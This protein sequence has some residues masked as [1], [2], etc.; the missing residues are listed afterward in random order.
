LRG[1]D[2]VERR[3]V[4]SEPR[5]PRGIEVLAEEDGWAVEDGY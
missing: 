5:T 1:A 2:R 4:Y 3:M